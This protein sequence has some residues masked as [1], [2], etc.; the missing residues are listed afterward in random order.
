[1]SQ[2][3]ININV[4]VA[5]RPYRLKIKP[6]EEETVRQA[7]KSINDKLKEFSA[8]YGAKDKQDYLA[9]VT[10]LFAV[11]A[12]NARKKHVVEDPAVTEKLAALNTL[13]D[14]VLANQ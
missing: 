5:D 8:Q 11:E 3:L 13:L 10:I 2:E 9:M 6:Q 4:I 7:A 14:N 1:M 12:L